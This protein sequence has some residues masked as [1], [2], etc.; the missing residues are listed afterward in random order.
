MNQKIFYVMRGIQGSGKSF[1]AKKL[2]ENGQIFSADDYF[3]IEG[4]YNW[5]GDK[6]YD[7][8]K[9]NDRRILQ[10]IESDVSPIIIDNT[11]ITLDSLRKCKKFIVEAKKKGYYIEI[12]ETDT[13]WRFDV[14]E[15]FKRNTHNV[16]RET[17][18]KA[19]KEYVK[20]VTV[21]TI[22]S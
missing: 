10:A 22:V 8:H 2:V 19:V 18:E 11:N 15:L 14:D 4:E 3:M 1:L 5:S 17:I 9:W 21:E 6:L 12:V 16:P 7:A 20:D 13:S